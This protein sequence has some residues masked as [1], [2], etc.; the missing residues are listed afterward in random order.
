MVQKIVVTETR[1]YTYEP[2]FSADV[3]K[4]NEISDIDKALG[5]DR[6]DYIDGRLDLGEIDDKPLVNSEWT[7]L[8]VEDEQAPEVLESSEPTG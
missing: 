7:I 2:D 5:F 8:E 6:Q 1:I 4:E 3:Y